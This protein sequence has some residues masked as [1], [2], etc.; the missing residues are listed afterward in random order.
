M[1]RP[2]RAIVLR[3]LLKFSRDR[4]RLFLSLFMSGIL[5]FVF[6]YVTRSAVT[7]MGRPMDYLIS[8]IVIMT[9]FQTSMNNSMAIL[10]DISSGFMKEIL[11]SPIERW[12]IGLGQVLSSTAIAMLQGTILLAAGLFLGLRLDLLHGLLALL[13]MALSGIAF[14]SVGLYLAALTKDSSNFQLTVTLVTVPLT[15]LS[16]AY[17]PVTVLP[18][19]LRPVVCLNPLTYT[20]AAFRFAML[21]ME[22]LPTEALV[23]SGIAFPVGGGFVITPPLSALLVLAIGAL[24]LFLCVRR[25]SR[26]DFSSVKVFRRHR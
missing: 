9:V 7:G 25:F 1:I 16:G 14:S 19:I 12:Q 5:L 18:R 21:R 8:G 24:F 10:E 23:R 26:A 17:I 3:N 2:I 20:T 6:S 22:G 13:L 4:M 15:F 11:V